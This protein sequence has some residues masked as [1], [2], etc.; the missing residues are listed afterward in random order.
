MYTNGFQAFVT[1]DK[2]CAGSAFGN[3]IF[4]YLYLKSFNASFST[5]TIQLY[6]LSAFYYLYIN[7]NDKW[8]TGESE[9]ENIIKL[10]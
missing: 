7:I 10:T 2:F 9:I 3:N 5:N 1:I 4:N 8:I 6:T